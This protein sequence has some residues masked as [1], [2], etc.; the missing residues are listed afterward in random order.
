MRRRS[1]LRGFARSNSV[2]LPWPPRRTW[3]R[4]RSGGCGVASRAIASG[5]TPSLLRASSSSARA[6]RSTK[7]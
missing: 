2:A 3:W 4:R 5:I 1:A 7:G 6:R